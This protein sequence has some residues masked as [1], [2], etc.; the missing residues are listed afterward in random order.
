MKRGIVVLTLTFAFASPTYAAPGDAQLVQGTL[1]W[2]ARLADEPFIVVRA[3]DGRWY[4]AEIKSAK[5]LESGPH[6]VGGRIALLGIEAGRPHEIT[7]VVLAGNAAALALAL[8][9]QSGP[10]VTT[11]AVPALALPPS[12]PPTALKSGVTAPLQSPKPAGRPDPVVDTA[13]ARSATPQSSE[14]PGPSKAPTTD[15]PTAPRSGQATPPTATTTKAAAQPEPDASPVPAGRPADSRRWSELQGT[16]K[17]VDGKS[18]V[19]RAS[20]GQLVIV[21]VSSISHTTSPLTPGT[22]ITVYGIAGERDFQAIG[23][24]EPDKKSDKPL[25]AT[26]AAPASSEPSIAPKPV[27]AESPHPPK[28]VADTASPSVPQPARQSAVPS[29]SQPAYWYY[30]QSARAYYPTVRTCSEPW[31]P[32]VPRT[33]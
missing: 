30:C 7:A 11:P 24:I 21:D 5:R 12:E 23:L 16:V 4:Y 8:M 18:M 26:V 1:E 9:S 22:S 3:E 19:V 28:V 10:A 13:L 15:Q 14:S 20:E 6:T 17:L 2:P 33:R 27:I 29:K 32:M 25:T 31:V